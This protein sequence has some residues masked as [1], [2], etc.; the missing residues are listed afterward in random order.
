MCGRQVGVSGRTFHWK[1]IELTQSYSYGLCALLDCRP[2][3]LDFSEQAQHSKTTTNFLSLL[4]LHYYNS[5][6]VN[7]YS[8]LVDLIPLDSQHVRISESIDIDLCRFELSVTV[9]LLHQNAWG[10]E[11]EHFPHLCLAQRA[12]QGAKNLP[13]FVSL[14]LERLF[15]CHA[16]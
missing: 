13:F 11:L 7:C 9:Q 10:Q 14:L 15:A 8:Q 3:E 5:C 1:W 16:A 6:K 2:H 4:N 12:R